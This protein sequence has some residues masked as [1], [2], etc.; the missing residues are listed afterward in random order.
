MWR[1][2]WSEAESAAA[3]YPRTTL[4]L[5]LILQNCFG[6]SILE[7]KRLRGRSWQNQGAFH[8]VS[9]YS[10]KVNTLNWGLSLYLVAHIRG[11]KENQYNRPNRLIIVIFEFRSYE[12]WYQV[13]NGRIVLATL[14]TAPKQWSR[15]FDPLSVTR[16][17]DSCLTRG[18]KTPGFVPSPPLPPHRIE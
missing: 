14:R 5:F 6:I 11:D 4:L 13:C 18:P 16:I 15:I 7:A 8:A 1:P 2:L 3:T 17:P 10:T 12:D 9:S